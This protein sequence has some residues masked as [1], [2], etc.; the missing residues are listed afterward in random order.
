M[1]K[2]HSSVAWTVYSTNRKKGLKK[3]HRKMKTLDF[4]SLILSFFSFVIIIVQVL[5]ILLL[6][7]ILKKDND[8]YEQIV[9]NEMI[10]LNDIQ[11]LAIIYVFFF[12][13]FL[14]FIHSSAK[15]EMKWRITKII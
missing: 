5:T 2:K 8:Y 15:S 10:T 4:I 12:I 14:K 6:F 7:F 1:R 3:V 11:Y 13:F 9:E